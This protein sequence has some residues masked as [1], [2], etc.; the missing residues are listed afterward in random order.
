MN[1]PVRDVIL[2]VIEASLEA[3]LSAVRRLRKSAPTSAPPRK[4]KGKSHASMAYDVLTDAGRPLHLREIIE[5]VNT[6][7]GVELDPDS[8]GSALT[9][10]V[11]KKERFARSAKNTFAIL[12][13]GN[14]G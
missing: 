2:E 12:E 4:V 8:L 11:L 6:K 10:L 5:A 7:F 3:Q 14:A 9:K 1:D 13:Q